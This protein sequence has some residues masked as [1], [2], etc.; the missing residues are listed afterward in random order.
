MTLN[1]YKFE[2]S[3]KFTWY[4][5]FGRQQLQNKWRYTTAVVCL[6]YNVSYR[7]SCICKLIWEFSTGIPLRHCGMLPHQGEFFC[8]SFRCQIWLWVWSAQGY[9]QRPHSGCEGGVH[10]RK[11][12]WPHILHTWGIRICI[13]ILANGIKVDKSDQYM[14]YS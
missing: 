11:K 12:C 2:F 10:S 3:E 9:K 4:R 5:R 6:P 13:E 14:L 7:L 1:C 8:M